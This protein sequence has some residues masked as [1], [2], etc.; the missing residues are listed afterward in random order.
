M[1]RQ[2]KTATSSR[3]SRD[4]GLLIRP[5]IRLISAHRRRS[6]RGALSVS[7]AREILIQGRRDEGEFCAEC[8]ATVLHVAAAATHSFN[9]QSRRLRLDPI[10][11]AA[12]ILGVRMTEMMAR[13][14]H[15]EPPSSNCKVR[16]RRLLTKL[17][18]LRKRVKRTHFRIHGRSAFAEASHHWQQYLR[19]ARPYFL[20]CTC[21]RTLLP[22]PSGR[23]LRRL[24]EDQWMRYFRKELPTL[25]LEIPPDADLR[26]LAKRAFRII[27]LWPSDSTSFG[28][29]NGFWFLADCLDRS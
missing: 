29:E 23:R 27:H 10:E 21:N 15:L 5:G 7:L 1:P 3:I 2:N 28:G 26:G 11:L 18:R 4:E 22:D 20:F 24:M 12:C 6:D 25:G 19:F 8:Q 14:R 9:S 16:C 13:H 17:E